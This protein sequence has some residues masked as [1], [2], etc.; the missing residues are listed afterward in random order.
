MIYTN[1]SNYGNIIGNLITNN[2]HG[3]SLDGIEQGNCIVRNNTIDG[4]Y[5]GFY[6]NSSNHDTYTLTAENN[7]ISNNV[8]G[9]YCENGDSYNTISYNTFFPC[10]NSRRNKI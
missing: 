10:N 9:I 1:Y 3:L 4:H 8:Y 5:Y 7:S 6:W 2:E